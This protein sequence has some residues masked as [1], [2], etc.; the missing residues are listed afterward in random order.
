LSVIGIPPGGIQQPAA[1]ADGWYAISALAASAYLVRCPGHATWCGEVE[2]LDWSSNGRWLAISVTSYG[3]ANPYN[4]IHVIDLVTGIDRQIRSCIPGVECDWFDLDWSPDGSRLAYVTEGRIWTIRRDGSDHRW[5][6]TGSSGDASSPSWSPDGH[7]I[8]YALRPAPH[9]TAAVF[10]ARPDGSDRVVLI[11]GA[12]EPAWSPDGR[13]IALA[14]RC[15]GIKLITPTGHDVTPGVT[16][17]RK[18]GVSG[19]P[20]WSLDGERLA[21]VGHRGNTI[22][23]RPGVY[24]VDTTGRNL[25]LLTSRTNGSGVTGRADGSWQPRLQ[26]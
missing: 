6:P 11:D 1:K 20:V 21:I 14:S 8:A 3:S 7:W 4:G 19:L 25:R 24:L 17:C 16:A 18:I 26:P 2:S 9:E 15:G 13:R 5:L 10:R 12:S 23:S 22:S